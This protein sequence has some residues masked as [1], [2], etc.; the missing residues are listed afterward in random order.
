MDWTSKEIVEN[1]KGLIRT[2]VREELEKYT[3]D[4]AST[5]D[6]PSTMCQCL[7]CGSIQE[8]WVRDRA[9]VYNV[10]CKSC[11]DPL[12]TLTPYYGGRG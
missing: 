11:R 4:F 6:I 8:V 7:R 1:L 12:G 3:I 5:S 9:D 2:I 10:K